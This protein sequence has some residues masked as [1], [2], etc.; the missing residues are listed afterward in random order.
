MTV[1]CDILVPAALETQSTS[2]NAPEIKARMI[3]E[4]AD[5]PI[6]PEADLILSE[7]GVVVVPDIL[8]NAGA[9]IVGYFEWVQNLENQQ[10]SEGE[11]QTRLRHKIRK[12]TDQVLGTRARLID[13]FPRYRDQWQ[14]AVPDWPEIPPVNL[15]TSALVSAVDRCHRAA[16]LRGVWP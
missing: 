9:A 3:V 6:T 1:E 5:A 10:W 7:R 4:G 11:I 15:R 12:A 2:L 13:N 14:R 16:L 8:A